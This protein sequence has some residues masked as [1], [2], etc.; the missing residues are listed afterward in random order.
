[1]G[2]R[3]KFWHYTIILLR[4]DLNLTTLRV[5]E[6]KCPF[7]GSKS[8]IVGPHNLNGSN[9]QGVGKNSLDFNSVELPC[10]LSIC[11]GNQK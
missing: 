11:A 8:H 9:T 7:I 2:R 5:Y 1:M 4:I 3:P 10:L 6:A